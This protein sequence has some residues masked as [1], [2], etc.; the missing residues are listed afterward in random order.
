MTFPEFME[1][2]A[3]KRKSTSYERGEDMKTESP[4]VLEVR[5]LA[6]LLEENHMIKA[7][8]LRIAVDCVYGMKENFMR[9]NYEHRDMEA[10][11]DAAWESVK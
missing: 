1:M 8:A 5:E 2:V 7:S 4:R 11:N 10:E 9:Y 3:G 6:A